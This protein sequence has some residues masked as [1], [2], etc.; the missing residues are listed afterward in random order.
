MNIEV[1]FIIECIT[2]DRGKNLQISLSPSQDAP[3]FH[4][5][6]MHLKRNVHCA[7]PSRMIKKAMNSV[8][9]LAI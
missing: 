2:E 7:S 4:R 6:G 8:S 9:F 1:E 3:K 5:S